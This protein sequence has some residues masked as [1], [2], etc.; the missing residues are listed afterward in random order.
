M[1]YNAVLNIPKI[2]PTLVRADHEL[3]FLHPCTMCIVVEQLLQNVYCSWRGVLR[4]VCPAEQAFELSRAVICWQI[5]V[6]LTVFHSWVPGLGF[7]SP[8]LV[9][10]KLVL[11]RG[12]LV[13]LASPGNRSIRK[14]SEAM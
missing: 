6:L 14:D 9:E 10:V 3:P 13:T 11:E 2:N 5:F 7:S 1:R 4:A 8:W 12:V